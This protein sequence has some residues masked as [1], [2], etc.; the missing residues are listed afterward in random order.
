MTIILSIG[1]NVLAYASGLIVLYAWA[2]V[3][4]WGG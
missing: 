1:L 3:L 2:V 4:G